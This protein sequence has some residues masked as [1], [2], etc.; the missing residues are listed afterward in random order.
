[1][2]VG[3][4]DPSCFLANHLKF[5]LKFAK[6]PELGVLRYSLETNCTVTTFLFVNE[7]PPN[8]IYMPILPHPTNDV[9]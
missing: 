3:R 8:L 2:A 1:M 7:I 9:L 6:W 4:G 5:K